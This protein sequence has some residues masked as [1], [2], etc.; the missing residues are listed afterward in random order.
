MTGT[1]AKG[2]GTRLLAVL[3]LSL[4]LAAAYGAQVT[5]FNFGALSAAGVTSTTLP[6]Q[7]RLQD[8]VS[9]TAEVV[10]TGSPTTCKYAIEGRLSGGWVVIGKTDDCTGAN[11]C[12]PA[13]EECNVFHWAD[14]SVDEIRGRLIEI[15]GGSS[16]TASCQVKLVAR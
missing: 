3:A 2:Q 7:Q 12:Y 11:D 1:R 8:N 9:G 5:R 14:K 15:S 10:V 13:G 6:L 4:M 16:P